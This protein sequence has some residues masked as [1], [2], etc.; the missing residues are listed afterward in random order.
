MDGS[1]LILN[2]AAV[3]LVTSSAITWKVTFEP[4]EVIF[5]RGKK[6]N[7]GPLTALTVKFITKTEEVINV[8][9]LGNRFSGFGFKVHDVDGHD[10]NI[11]HNAIEDLVSGSQIGVIIC[12]TIKGKGVP[13]A[14]WEPI[15]H[16]RT[17]DEDLYK[18]ALDHLDEG[19]K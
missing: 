9:P 18:Q 6:I 14:E 2:W 12:N 16:Y 11:L 15:W 7:A 5:A 19:K 13:F 8:K 4:T 17:L 1:K 3:R 10:L